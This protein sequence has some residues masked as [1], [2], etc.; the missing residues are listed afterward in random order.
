MKNTQSR[1]HLINELNLIM[2]LTD[3]QLQLYTKDTM[4]KVVEDLSGGICWNAST[5]ID[6]QST[7]LTPN[8]F[9]E[10]SKYPDL[11]LAQV[12]D[13]KVTSSSSVTKEHFGGVRSG[14]KFIF[15]YH[16]DKFMQD[17]SYDLIAHFLFDIEMLSKVVVSTRQENEEFSRIRKR[18]PLDYQL[19]GINKFIKLEKTDRVKFIDATTTEIDSNLTPYF[20]VVLLAE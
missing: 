18:T 16:Y 14:S 5:K 6:D 13:L 11:T 1:Q 7:L 10:W 19:I 17:S 4:L 8:A 12:I 2:S 9:L 3:D 20:P 15:Q